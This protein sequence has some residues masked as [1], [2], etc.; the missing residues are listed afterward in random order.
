MHVLQSGE[1]PSQWARAF[2]AFDGKHTYFSLPQT[3]IRGPIRQA[4]EIK[5]G[6]QP[7][8][9]SKWNITPRLLI[10][11]TNRCRSMKEQ[12]WG[13]LKSVDALLSAFLWVLFFL[14][15]IFHEEKRGHSHD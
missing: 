5:M 2:W 12:V 6:F 9:E 13:T 8:T 14:G 10:W 11:E 1:L 4:V 15:C 3:K 7:N